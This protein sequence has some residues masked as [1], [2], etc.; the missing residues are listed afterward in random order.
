MEGDKLALDLASPEFRHGV[1]QR[2]WEL[3][4]RADET[5]YVRLFAPDDREYLAQLRCEK[6]GDEPIEGKFVDP[7]T[8][9]CVESA[10][11]IGN[12][13][14]E[15]WVKFKSPNLFICWDQDADAVSRHQE[16]RPRKAWLKTT[17]Q[18]VAYLNFLR[19]L[20]NVPARGYQRQPASPTT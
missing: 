7:E 4:E 12:P 14:F 20:L 19:E 18:I 13:T 5:V 1:E 9:A 6:Y 11:P 3:V 17:N 10:W 2:F 8:R 15:Q 16:W